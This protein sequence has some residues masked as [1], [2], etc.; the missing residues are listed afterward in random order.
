MASVPFNGTEDENLAVGYIAVFSLV[1]FVGTL[2]IDLPSLIAVCVG[3]TV[4]TRRTSV[5]NDGLQR[6]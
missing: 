4:P 6:S 2:I 5:Y 3:H 1:F